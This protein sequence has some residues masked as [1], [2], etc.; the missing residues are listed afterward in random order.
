MTPNLASVLVVLGVISLVVVVSLVLVFQRV[1]TMLEGVVGTSGQAP[2]GGDARLERL[3]QFRA[4]LRDSLSDVRR[5][6]QMQHGQPLSDRPLPAEVIYEGLPVLTPAHGA[7]PTMTRVSFESSGSRMESRI[8]SFGGAPAEEDSAE[9]S[10]G[11]GLAQR[12][13][14]GEALRVGHDHLG[15]LEEQATL[16]ESRPAGVQMGQIGATFTHA[17]PDAERAPDDKRPK[18]FALPSRLSPLMAAFAAMEMFG[19]PRA[20]APYRSSDEA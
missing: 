16:Q 14:A 1:K 20:L 15:Q 13:A 9:G 10:G 3:R 4:E 7:G 11:P 5:R 2:G 12:L 19:P 8:A 6:G 17:V 18:G